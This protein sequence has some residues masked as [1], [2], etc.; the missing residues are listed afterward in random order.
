MLSWHIVTAST[1]YAAGTY[2]D[3][4][5]YFLSDTGEI[6][7]G[8]L[9][10]SEAIAFV[11]DTASGATFDTELGKITNPARRKL[12]VSKATLAAKTYDGTAWQWV[13]HPVVATLDDT[14]TTDPVSGKAVADYVADVI[15]DSETFFHAVAYDSTSKVLSFTGGEDGKKQVTL[16]GLACQITYDDTTGKLAIKDKA[17]T[18]LSS[19]NLDLE[20]FVKSGTYNAT[21]RKITLYFDDAKTDYVEIDVADLISIV[22]A[23]DTDS[24]DLTATNT[25]QGT[26][27]KADVKLAAG[28]G[29]TD[30][31]IQVIAGEGLY[32]AP[33]DLSDYMKLV[34]NAT[35]GDI[36]TVN[37]SGQAVDSGKKIGAGTISATPDANTLATEAAVEAIRAALQTNIDG[38]IAKVAGATAG[39]L[40][41]LTNDGQLSDSGKAIGG[42][43]LAATPDANTLATEA[44][45]KKYADDLKTN[46]IV[47]DVAANASETTKVASV[48]AIADAL[49]WQTTM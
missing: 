20:R 24:V 49:S 7:K 23:T 13:I 22:S 38:K 15:G 34:D 31:L 42:A 44:A 4:K 45:V 29:H 17:G 30:N 8:A 5:L 10:F 26:V 14:N 28:V 33:T 16:N 25:Q 3:N 32:V 36:L 41:T 9:P 1:Y 37:A 21:T 48:K 47:Q 43:T 39:N 11:D 40:P 12:Y 18:E 46:S 27:L 6:Y 2:D 19:I 35:N